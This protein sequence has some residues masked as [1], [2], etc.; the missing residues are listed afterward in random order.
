V[1]VRIFRH[2]SLDPSVESP[3]SKVCRSG[4]TFFFPMLVISE[5]SVFLAIRVQSVVRGQVSLHMFKYLF[6]EELLIRRVLVVHSPD[7]W[8]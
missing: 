5:D 4:W 3:L 8:P 7:E 1:P 6:I 2:L